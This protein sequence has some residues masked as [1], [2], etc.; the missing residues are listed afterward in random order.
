MN[1]LVA[2]RMPIFLGLTATAGTVFLMMV[3]GGGI[4]DDGRTVS[5]K[6]FLISFPCSTYCTCACH[7]H[8][9]P[10][11]AVLVAAFIL[12]YFFFLSGN[13]MT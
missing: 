7:L 12:V 4:F 1:R 2:S 6:A 11:A 3:S 9:G 10:L 5:N 8:A 13:A